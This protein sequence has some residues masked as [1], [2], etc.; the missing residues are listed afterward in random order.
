MALGLWG[1]QQA[2]PFSS[3]VFPPPAL[4]L[5]TRAEW[6]AVEP[7]M[8]AREEH[9][10]FDP[11]NNRDGW[12]VYTRPLPEI[13]N[14][15]IVHHSA[16][17]LTDG[18]REIQQLHMGTRGYADIAYHFL[19]DAEGQLY[20]GRSLQVRGAHTGGFNT[21]TIGV[22]LLGNFEVWEPP[23]AQWETLRVAAGSLAEVYTLTHLAGH[24]DFQPTATVCPGQFLEERL[25][26]LAA[27]LGLE[28]GIGGYRPPGPDGM[29]EG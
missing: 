11:V 18:P 9:G 29:P 10:L 5:I 23:A 6:G 13:L 24:K 16:L 14:T 17:P 20:E 25:P 8:D 28:W 2:T 27:D 7:S 1:R 22:V 19:I 15:L 3:P 26:Q 12:L 21:G 4:R